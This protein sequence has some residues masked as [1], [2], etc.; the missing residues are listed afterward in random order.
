METTPE[1]QEQVLAISKIAD[2]IADKYLG[3]EPDW[4]PLRTVLPLEWCDGFM[5]MYRVEEGDSVIELY[6]H[7][8]TRRY[9]NLD[10]A[11]RAYRF[12]GDGYIQ[13]PVAVA[14]DQVFSGIE[15]MGWSRET[16]YDEEFV[17]RKHRALREAG[18]TVITTGAPGSG[19]LLDQLDSPEAENVS[20][21]L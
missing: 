11:N 1:D 13:I 19:E 7:G 17:A 16:K 8:I 14:V 15:D 10:Q 6:K 9:L 5:W 4:E 21:E 20:D 12:T 2:Q 3:G 18:W